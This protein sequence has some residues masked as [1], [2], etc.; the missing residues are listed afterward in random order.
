LKTELKELE[1][2]RQKISEENDLL[3]SHASQFENEKALC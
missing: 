2:K 1:D 3:K